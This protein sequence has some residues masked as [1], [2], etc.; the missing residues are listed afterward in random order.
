MFT[1][2]QIDISYF[3]TQLAIEVVRNC[4]FAYVG[5]ISSRASP[6]LVPCNSETGLLNA[7]KADGIA[8]FIV[9]EQLAKLVPDTYGLGI[10]PDPIAIAWKIQDLISE[11]EGFQWQSFSSRIEPSVL[12]SPGAW[13]SPQD[14]VIGAGTKIFPNAVIF[15]RTII[16]SNCTIGANT[17]VGSD[18]FEVHQSEGIQKILNQS[19]GVK[20]DDHVDIQ[21]SCTIVRATFGGF[22]EIGA[23]S[24][25]D[26]QVHLAHDCKVGERV[27]IAASA[28]ISGRVIIGDDAFLGPNVSIANGLEI[29]DGGYISIGSV[30]TQNVAPKTKVTGN[31]AIEHLKWLNFIR[32]I[33]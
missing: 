12:I 24:K 17:V 2:N 23:M 22:T 9:T 5:K 33:R 11:M 16:G 3:A 19:G 4:H 18:A 10:A 6:R 29:G 8:G 21:A 27:R 32:S 31:F 26:C 15:P 1:G 28:E 30:V 25:L 13:I 14:V 7:L 20:I